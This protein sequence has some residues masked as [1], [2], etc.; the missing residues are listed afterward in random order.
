MR[1]GKK[2]R[3]SVVLTAIAEEI[4]QKYRNGFGLKGPLSVG[5]EL[6][7][8]LPSD[9]QL[10]RVTAAETADKEARVMRAAGEAVVEQAAAEA[11]EEDR[12]GKRAR[13]TG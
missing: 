5:L 6:F 7:D 4:L 13:K 11:R 9:E 12:R 10:R 1:M 3:T 8:G 2:I